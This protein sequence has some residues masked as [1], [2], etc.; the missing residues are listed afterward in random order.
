MARM[1]SWVAQFLAYMDPPWFA[2]TIS[3][4]SSQDHDCAHI[5]GLSY[6]GHLC[7]PGLDGFRALPPQQFDDLGRPLRETGSG[8]AGLTCLAITTL[9]PTQSSVGA[10][11][12]GVSLCLPGSHVPLRLRG[13]AIIV[14]LRQQCPGDPCGLIGL[15]DAGTVLPA[16][17]FDRLEPATPGIRLAIDDPQHRAGTMD[18]QGAQVAIP[19]LRHP[20]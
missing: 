17:G 1:D 11:S 18:E 19:A 12:C 8:R 14:T 13:L 5:Y 4:D 6:G 2:R 3:C 10:N 7:S 15:G 20:P 9:L 16:P